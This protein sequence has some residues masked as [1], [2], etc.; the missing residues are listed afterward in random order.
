MSGKRNI[1]IHIDP[2]MDYWQEENLLPVM[3]SQET[4]DGLMD[5]RKASRLQEGKDYDYVEE[6]E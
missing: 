3:V 1:R 5:G 4:L 6:D 2:E